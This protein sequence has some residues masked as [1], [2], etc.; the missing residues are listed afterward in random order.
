MQTIKIFDKDTR[1]SRANDRKMTPADRRRS[2]HLAEIAA[3]GIGESIR[4]GF[5]EKE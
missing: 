5:Y 4:L 1:R 3:T 2:G